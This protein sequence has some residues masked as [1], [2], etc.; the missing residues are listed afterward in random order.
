MD[1]WVPGTFS[2]PPV[3]HAAADTPGYRYL[4]AISSTQ[5]FL[6]SQQM[7]PGC[8]HAC[9]Y[10]CIEAHTTPGAYAAAAVCLG[11]SESVPS[12]QASQLQTKQPLTTQLCMCCTG[13]ITA[14]QHS[15]GDTARGLLQLWPGS[16]AQAQA[17]AQSQSF[18]GFSQSQ[19]QSQGMPRQHS[20][21][22][23]MLPA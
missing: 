6:E 4:V 17:M 11:V 10:A 7:W 18:G 23:T 9:G 3:H 15:L 2:P 12:A 1:Q 13:Q 21:E 19:A 22:V 8:L 20:F 14:T 5:M 16:G